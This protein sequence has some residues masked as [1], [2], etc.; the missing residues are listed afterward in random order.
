MS[1]ELDRPRREG[2]RRHRR[3]ADAVD[4]AGG[5]RRARGAGCDVVVTGTGRPADRYPA[6]E[7]AAGWRDVESVAEEVRAL[8]RRAS[9]LVADVSSEEGV[10][11]LYERVLAELGR[12]DVLVNNAAAARGEDRVPVTELDPG[13]WD[14]VVA[15]NLR[16]TF[17]MGRAF[18]RH[19]RAAEQ[20][21]A[22]VN[23]SSIGGKLAGPGTAAYSAS[24][25]GVQALTSSMAKEP[26]PRRDPGQRDLPR[27]GRD[28]AA[29]RPGRRRLG[30]LRPRHRAAAAR[31]DPARGRPDRPS[32]SPATRRAGSPARPGTSSGGQLT[33]R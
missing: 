25:A 28:L 22:I 32:S 12:V 10:T 17:L 23:V 13:A 24:K 9:P 15:V 2:R 8:G 27:R 11:E 4:R 6:D 26:R 20:P 19:C 29:R 33:T 14:T 21:G 18:A 3:R 30:R 1:Y 5:R 16:G 7:R 31:R